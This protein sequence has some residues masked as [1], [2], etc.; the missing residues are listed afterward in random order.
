MC[1]DSDLQNEIDLNLYNELVENK[2]YLKL[3]LDLPNFERSYLIKQILMKLNYFF[4]IF[5]LK[6][7]FR[8]LT[9]ECSTKK[10]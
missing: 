6:D 8:Y 9:N 4:R 10:I 2:Q 7:T 1:S 3:Y 5:E